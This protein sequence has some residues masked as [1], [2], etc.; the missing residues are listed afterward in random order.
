MG[1]A[2]LVIGLA[3]GGRLLGTF[4]G[5]ATAAAATMIVLG[6]GEGFWRRDKVDTAQGPGGWGIGFG[7]TKKAV[8]KL[9][10]RVDTQ[11]EEVNKRLY[12]LEYAVF[13]EEER[14]RDETG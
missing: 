1:V 3:N 11:M 13:K 8:G 14:G 10:E 12:D 7:Q 6:I 9:N 2:F 5:A 4:L